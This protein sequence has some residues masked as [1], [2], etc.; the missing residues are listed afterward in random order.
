MCD[1]TPKAFYITDILRIDHLIQTALHF[2][3]SKNNLDVA[4]KL[5]ARKASARVKDKRGQLPLHR[6]AAV[7][8]VPMVNLLLDNQSPLNAT[9]VANY[10]ALHH[11]MMMDFLACFFPRSSFLLSS[12]LARIISGVS[13]DVAQLL[14]ARCEKSN[15][16]RPRRHR[17]CAAQSGS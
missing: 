6:A 8:S 2:C 1:P 5:I 7:G 3:A 17:A 14:T 11:G 10:T 9:D 12:I 13:E 4:R 15:L 16:R